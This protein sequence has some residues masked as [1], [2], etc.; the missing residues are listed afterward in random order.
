LILAWR[1]A[2]AEWQATFERLYRAY[3]GAAEREVG[4]RIGDLAAAED[5]LVEVEAEL[6]QRPRRPPTDARPK[7]PSLADV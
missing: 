1:Q 2:T 4:R 7:S 5:R 3:V 6:E